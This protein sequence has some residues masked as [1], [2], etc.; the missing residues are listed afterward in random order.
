[1]AQVAEAGSGDAARFE[2]LHGAGQGGDLRRVDF[3]ADA[4]RLRDIEC[5]PQK[6]D[7]RTLSGGQQKRLCIARAL[8][9]EPEVLLLDEPTSS[10]DQDSTAVIE[11][12]LTG[13]KDRLTILVV[14]HYLEQ[15]IG[16]S[17]RVVKFAGDTIIA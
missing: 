14:S 4:A 17:D 8:V 11:D 6:A 7:A 5:M 3:Q 1:M 15:V 9:L 10:L 12:L 2:K 13:L 16:I